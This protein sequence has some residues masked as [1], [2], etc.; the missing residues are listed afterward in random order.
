MISRWHK[1]NNHNTIMKISHTIFAGLALSVALAG[2][3]SA[4]AMTVPV[5]SLTASAVN[6]RVSAGVNAS[7]TA[8]TKAAVALATRITNLKTR[9]AQEITRRVAIMNDVTSKVNAMVRLSASEKSTLSTSLQTQITAMN[10]LG[11][12]IANDT[13][14]TALKTDVQS[15]TKS[16]R[17]FMLVVP[18]ARIAAT[19]DAIDTTVATLTTIGTKF[20]TRIMALENAGKDTSGLITLLNDFTAKSSDAQVQANA[21]VTGTASLQPDNGN[22]TIMR[23]NNAAFA[24]AKADIKTAQNDLQTARNDAQQ[25]VNALKASGSVNA[26]TTSVK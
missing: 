19:T 9:A 6:A 25:I 17:I 26:T 24:T 1:V 11:A 14:L 2:A 12:Q 4:Q 5:S 20:Q 13:D 7:T 3:G 23:S 10:T 18:Q 21:A 8:G 16:Y 22:Q 15:I